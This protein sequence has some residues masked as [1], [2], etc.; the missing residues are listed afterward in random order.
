MG[1][2][3]FPATLALAAGIICSSRFD[4]AESLLL[5]VLLLA[6]LILIFLLR[7]R[8]GKISAFLIITVFFVI[9]YLH[10]NLYL[11]QPPE[12]I[13]IVNYLR[14]EPVTVAGTI[15]A[16]P[17]LYPEKAELLID[18]HRLTDNK[19]R[20]WSPTGNILLS[21]RGEQKFS[22]GDVIAVRTRLR[23]VHNFHNPGGFDYE[24]Y[25]KFQG[26]R[27]RGHIADDSR[28]FLMRK[29]FGNL[30]RQ[31][32]EDLRE[33][34][35]SFIDLHAP[36]PEKEIIKACILGDQQEIPR[37]IRDA[38]SKTGTSHIIAISGFNMGLV[39]LFSILLARMIIK[40][41]PYL[42][43]RWDLYKLSY[44][45]AVPPVILYTF[46]A[47]AGMS[48]LRATLMIL[49]FIA[50][51][52]LARS[53][54]LFN[55]LV[56]A[57][58]MILIAYPPALFDISF[59]LSFAAVA[60]IMFISPRLTALLPGPVEKKENLSRIAYHVR[61]LSHQSLVF[62][63]VSLAATLGT[64]PLIACYFNRISL[65]SLPAN[66]LIVPVLGILAVP[67][68]MA[69][70]FLLPFSALLSG[71]CLD[72]A[73]TLVMISLAINDFFTALS[74]ASI[75]ISTPSILE[76]L[77]YYLL[78]AAA[79]LTLP[80]AA[81]SS[82]GSV[83][84]PA[85]IKKAWII[86]ILTAAVLFFI[87]DIIYIQQTKRNTGVLTATAI[88]V[89]QGSAILVRL[90]EGRTILID[91][92]G[93]PNS[94]FDVG[95]YVVAPFLWH[96]RIV[97]IDIVVLTHP[98]PDHLNG[99]P[100]ILNNFSVREFW[101]N[102][103]N[104]QTVEHENLLQIIKARGIV[105]RHLSAET[106]PLLLAG[107]RF[108]FLNPP[109]RRSGEAAA[110]Y[111]EAN[112]RSL[113]LRI[114][115]GGVSF[116]VGGDISGTTEKMIAV[117]KESIRSAVMFVPHHGGRTSSTDI[118]LQAIRPAAAIISVGGGNYFGLP[119]PDTLHRLEK[120]GAKIY[121]TDLQGAIT[122][123]TDGRIFSLASFLEPDDPEVNFQKTVAQPGHHVNK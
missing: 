53:R 105:H 106:E 75:Y 65:V 54:D 2:P 40:K 20:T 92:G 61:R 98:H 104:P 115:Y 24:R 3:L 118:L 12:Q 29:G 94:T 85:V 62:L 55:S 46:I 36:S 41:F 109:L 27:V 112:D 93:F 110:N 39:A 108:E 60:A 57:A 80:A 51:L 9:G 5:G 103:D 44:L 32:L 120:S 28:I 63:I 89:G 50:A 43:L 30:W 91:G 73:G 17:Q 56:L 111:H 101:D 96:E 37:D 8:N 72:L 22:Y 99:L 71:W 66:I 70:I 100:F 15:C 84:Q 74:W 25:L 64:L 34:I 10:L 78:L 95:R 123:T 87:G 116:F 88:D 59:Q 26:I 113:V 7:R 47:G 31:K 83:K 19:G 117:G 79:V 23:R 97:K 45:A 67:V 48:V 18:V 11:R 13:N 14:T 52:L 49:A 16:P 107:A 68:S 90:P 114:S 122:A 76:I 6:L 69:T 33:S 58:F 4:I 86:P 82:A 121:R 21:Y 1:H 77:F 102:G 81:A 119:H 38:F 42:L 35:R